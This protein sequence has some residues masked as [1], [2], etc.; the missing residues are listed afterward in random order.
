VRQDYGG[1]DARIDPPA[2][3]HPIENQFH[4]GIGGSEEGMH[5]DDRFII[6][7]KTAEVYPAA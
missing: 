7:T 1:S 3:P 6:L 2:A 4:H 5:L